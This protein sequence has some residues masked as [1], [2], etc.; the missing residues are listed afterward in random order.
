[1]EIFQIVV[2]GI[3]VLIILTVLRETNPE[4]AVILSLVTGIIIFV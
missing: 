2:L 3:V 4:I 1:M